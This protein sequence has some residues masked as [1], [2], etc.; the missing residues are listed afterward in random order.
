ME[1]GYFIRIIGPVNIDQITKGPAKFYD[2][3]AQHPSGVPYGPDSTISRVDYQGKLWADDEPPK[4]EDV[5]HINAVLIPYAKPIIHIKSYSILCR[6][7]LPSNFDAALPTIITLGQVTAYNTKTKACTL[8]TGDYN[9]KENK[10][11]TVDLIVYLTGKQFIH[12][13]D[14]RVGSIMLA[15]GSMY[16]QLDISA[17]WAIAADAVH[18]LPL[19]G[20]ATGSNPG[21]PTKKRKYERKNTFGSGVDTKGA[22][23]QDVEA[24]EPATPSSSR[25][26]GK[27]RAAASKD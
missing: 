5:V 25:T 9:H 3:E 17:K 1:Q 6:G 19:T 24:A 14:P 11:I 20:A 2:F 21:T 18:Y 4:A 7:D 22:D 27:T 16:H 23:D 15:T 12:T 26:A 13:P 10:R 8:H